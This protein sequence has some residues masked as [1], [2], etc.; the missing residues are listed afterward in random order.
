MN[1]RIKELMLKAGYAAPHIAPRAQLLVTLIIKECVIEIHAAEV[2]DL[3]SKAYYLDKVA[4]HIENY[5]GVT[6]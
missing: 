3:N 4:E 5:F 2:G 6:E 1:E